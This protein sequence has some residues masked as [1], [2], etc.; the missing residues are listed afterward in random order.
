MG[1]SASLVAALILS[2]K[3]VEVF[4]GFVATP[5]YCAGGYCTQ[6]FGTVNKPDGTQVKP[7]DPPITVETARAWMKSEL[8]NNYMAGVLRASPVLIKHPDALAAMT[9]FA[10]N[11]GVPRYRSSTLK[12]KIDAEDW[13][14]A[15]QEL[16]KWVYGGGRKLPGLVKRRAT[17]A[18][19]LP[20]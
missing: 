11:L 4:E 20:K 7:T 6:G 9:S 18:R 1:T 15:R 16:A 19:L 17:E 5:Y 2:S 8:Q 13:D 3:L 14:G 12:R 10:Y